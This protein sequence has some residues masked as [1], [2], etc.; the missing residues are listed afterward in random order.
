MFLFFFVFIIIIS[1]FWCVTPA[2]LKDRC[3]VESIGHVNI[4]SS[5][6]AVFTEKS[7][8]A[9]CFVLFY[10]FFKMATVVFFKY[11]NILFY[12]I[13][14]IIIIIFICSEFCHTLKWNSRGFYHLVMSICR[15]FS[16]VAVRGCLLW[17]VRSLGK[18]L[19]A[20][21]LLHSVLQGQ[22]CLLL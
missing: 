15:A 9:A 21:D 18:T 13:F 2:I 20:F 7:C 11:W 14:I 5:L 17:P 22:S 19:L 8:Y 4:S 1:I 12:F 10:S 3:H 6:K 16:C